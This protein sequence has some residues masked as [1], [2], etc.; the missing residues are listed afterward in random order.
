[1]LLRIIMA[2]ATGNEEGFERLC[3][4]V[5]RAYGKHGTRRK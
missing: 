4:G 2:A 1:M 3:F 5:A